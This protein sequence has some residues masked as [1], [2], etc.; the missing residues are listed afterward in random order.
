M[1][2]EALRARFDAMGLFSKW[3]KGAR[4]AVFWALK[5]SAPGADRSGNG[6][7]GD[8]ERILR[9][10]PP[11]VPPGRSRRLVRRRCVPIPPR[12]VSGCIAIQASDRV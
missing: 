8:A 4:C 7:A 3:K 2:D 1:Y 12:P 9:E 5:R 11:I 6:D 10:G